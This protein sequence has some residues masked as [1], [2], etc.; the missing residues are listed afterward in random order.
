[1]KLRYTVWWE[2]PLPKEELQTPPEET[3]RVRDL[4]REQQQLIWTGIQQLNPDLA[5]L[6]REDPLYQLLKKNFDASLAL[7]VS[8]YR[9][10]L[11]EAQRGST[12]SE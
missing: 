8:E 6:L 2:Q 4:P 10:Y 7:T 1:V 5:S 11:S 12:T 9:R 3:V